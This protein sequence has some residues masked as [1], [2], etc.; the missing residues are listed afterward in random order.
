VKVR[1][2]DGVMEDLAALPNNRLKEVALQW[3]R[4]LERN[5][6]LGEM[7]GWRAST[8]DLQDCRKLYFDHHDEPLR[9][10]IDAPERKERYYRIVYRVLE[11][12]DAV[13]IVAVGPGH[14][15][16]EIDA[17]YRVAGRRLGRLT[18]IDDP[19]PDAPRHRRGPPSSRSR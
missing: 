7:C 2:L 6:H 5:P 18:L 12:D 13:E 15:P 16:P 17:V 19:G 9:I 10:E 3:M 1:F 14:P 11:E 8:G 4:R